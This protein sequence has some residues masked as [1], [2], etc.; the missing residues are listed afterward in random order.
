M[1]YKDAKTILSAKGG[2]NLYRGCTHGCIYCDSRSECYRMEHDF[3][4]V[5]VK[6]NAPELLRAALRKKRRKCMIGAGSMSDP[7][8]PLEQTVAAWRLSSG[9][10]SER[11]SS[12][13]RILCFATWICS[14]ASTAAPDVWCR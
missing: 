5:E 9:R 1:H 11:P 7:Y 2:M 4:D 14:S 13:S 10:A 8:N 6:G 12:P 3:E